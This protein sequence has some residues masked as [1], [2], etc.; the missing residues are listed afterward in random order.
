VKA[1]EA[2]FL[3]R[4]IAKRRHCPNFLAK[5]LFFLKSTRQ[6]VPLFKERVATSMPA[7]YT[8]NAPQEKYRQLGE[9]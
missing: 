3:G 2:F 8:F 9:L 6:T 7:G 1:C 5:I 4:K